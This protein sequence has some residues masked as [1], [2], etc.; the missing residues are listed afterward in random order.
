LERR[1]SGIELAGDR[2][3]GVVGETVHQPVPRH[4]VGVHQR[5]GVLVGAARAALD[6]VAGDG[7]RRAREREER[8]RELLGED[9]HRLD[10]VR[11]V[12]LG[13]EH[14]HAGQIGSAPE[15]FGCH[16][17]GARGDVDAEPDGVRGHDDVA[18]Q[19][20]RI[21]AVADD[22]LQRDLG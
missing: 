16:R 6:Q 14:A 18:V 12:D 9:A 19:N 15:R 22:R 7:E 8:H 1:R 17:P 11:R 10:H 13:F 5:L 21:D 20:S 3:D 4:L 2:R